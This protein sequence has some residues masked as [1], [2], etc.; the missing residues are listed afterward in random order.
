MVILISVCHAAFTPQA[1]QVFVWPQDHWLMP[2][3]QINTQPEN[4]HLSPPDK[5]RGEQLAEVTSTAVLYMLWKHWT[6]QHHSVQ[7]VR[8]HKGQTAQG[9]SLSAVSS[10]TRGCTPRPVWW[11]FPPSTLSSTDVLCNTLLHYSVQTVHP[12]STPVVLNWF[13]FG[14]HHHPLVTGREFSTFN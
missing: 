4:V 10:T 2:A 14:T 11:L 12:L 1:K 9:I 8:R 13:G 3:T 5:R 6:S 7:W